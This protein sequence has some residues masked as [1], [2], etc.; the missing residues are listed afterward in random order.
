[1]IHSYILYLTSTALRRQVVQI[2]ELDSPL[3]TNIADSLRVALKACRLVMP[4]GF[5]RA[6]I[7]ALEDQILVVQFGTVITQARKKLEDC[8]SSLPLPLSAQDQLDVRVKMH[9]ALNLVEITSCPP[10]HAEAADVGQLLEISGI[11]DTLK[12]YRELNLDVDRYDLR[13]RASVLIER[14]CHEGT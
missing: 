4:K 1:L 8:L 2:I 10:C 3:Y 12:K 14:W 5:T 11:I 6:F 7:E 9:D 13:K